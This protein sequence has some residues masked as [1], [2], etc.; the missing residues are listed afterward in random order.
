MT[1]IVNLTPHTINIYDVNGNEV[2]KFESMGIARADSSETVVD[3]INDI[4]V[5]EMTYG[6]PIGLPDPI[7]GT[8]YIVNMLTIQAAVQVGR[9]TSDLYTTADLVRNDK[10]QRLSVVGNLVGYKSPT[11]FPPRKGL[12]I[13]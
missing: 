9:T 4:P 5:V 7:E 8:A 6:A 11:K 2:S 10:G 12:N 3:Y 13:K 1:N